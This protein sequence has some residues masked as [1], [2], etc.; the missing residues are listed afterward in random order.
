MTERIRLLVVEDDEVDRLA[1]RR[2]VEH[3]D[4]DAEL[5]EAITADEARPLLAQRF[6]CLLLD[7]DLPGVTGIELTRRLRAAGDPTPV[8]L[9]TGAHDDDLLQTA[10]DAGITDFIPKSDVSPRR[11]ALRVRFAVRA[12]SE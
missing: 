7:H 4:L 1:I 12:R 10:A 2:A 5:R 11:I 6:D 9:V 8:I 3:S